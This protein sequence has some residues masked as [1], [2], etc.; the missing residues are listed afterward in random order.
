MYRRA[1]IVIFS[2]SLFT[3]TLTSQG[4]DE[5]R[6]FS[7]GLSKLSSL[8]K[9][10][11]SLH[12]ERS[13]IFER[14]TNT[15]RTSPD[16]KPLYE[17]F[18]AITTEIANLNNEVYSLRTECVNAVKTLIALGTEEIVN[19]ILNALFGGKA[20]DLQVEEAT[21]N[22]LASTGNSETIK[23][24]IKR[25]ET[26]KNESILIALCEVMR[27]KGEKAATDGLIS[28]LSNSDFDVVTSAAK[29]LSKI[30]SKK[31][32]EPMIEA[33]ARAEKENKQSAARGI[34][35]AIQDMTGQYNLSNALDFLNWWNA[36]GKDTYKEGETPPSRSD[37]KLSGKF[38]TILY[39]NITSKRVIFICDVSGSMAA[40]GQVPETGRGDNEKQPETGGG[41]KPPPETPKLG[42]GGIQPGFVGTRIEILKIELAYVV[43]KLLAADAKFNIITYSTDVRS[44]K[45]SLTLAT[46][47]N[48][49]AAIEFVK[50]MQP[51]GQ[52]NTY[53]ALEEA[54]NDKEVD[55]IYFLSDGNPTTGTIVNH[56]EI[57]AA[58][59]YLNKGRNIIINTIGLLV[60]DYAGEDKEKLV[61]FLKALAE[62]NGGTARIILD[63]IVKK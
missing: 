7:S 14:L 6:Q 51:Y 1:I 36:K 10:L 54:F 23:Y 12:K 50:A 30:R 58:V 25:L 35:I 43:N 31:A 26:E 60:G 40:R 22:L 49:E 29:A 56:R 63:K 19:E 53:G 9:K 3:S 27:R 16:Y 28:L 11:E 62:E 45:K 5:L 47:E 48:R 39:G 42:E 13:A 57:L 38:E 37:V 8:R 44:W 18:N 21:L 61:S 59:R 20:S 34:L 2:L 52:T 17:R 4:K 46:K 15:P 32:V 33:L 41:L 55:T 24:L